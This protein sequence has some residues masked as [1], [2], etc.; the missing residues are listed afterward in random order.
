MLG[1]AFAHCRKFPTAASRRS[2]GRVSVPMWLF[3]LSVQ[4]RIIDL[5]GRY[6]TNY[7]MRRKAILAWSKRTFKYKI[8]RFYIL[9]SISSRFQ[10]LSS[11]LGQVPYVLLTHLPLEPKLSY[12]MHVL[13][14]VPAFILSQDRTLHK[15]Y[16]NVFIILYKVSI[17]L[18]F[19]L[20]FKRFMFSFQRPIF[21]SCVLHTCFS[22]LL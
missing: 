10:P 17:D 18:K 9:S 22:I 13:G 12:D 1:Q 21:C 3:H 4:L 6:L 20:L 19:L 8:M 5:V 11:S 16:K 2:L 14:M 7:L 15:I